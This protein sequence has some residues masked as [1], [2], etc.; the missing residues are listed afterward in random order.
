[1]HDFIPEHLDVWILIKEK[2]TYDHGIPFTP[3]IQSNSMVNLVIRSKKRNEQRQC[4][5]TQTQS[6][7][8]KITQ[9]Q[10]LKHGPI[11]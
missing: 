11:P 3:S 5:S 1:M 7:L 4:F 8:I 10:Y 2:F 9:E 6:N